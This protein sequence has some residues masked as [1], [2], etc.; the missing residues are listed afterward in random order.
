MALEVLFKSSF[1]FTFCAKVV[2]CQQL[3]KTHKHLFDHVPTD[4]LGIPPILDEA[5]GPALAQQIR[6]SK[7]VP[8]LLSGS[9]QPAANQVNM[10][11]KKAIAVAPLY[12][13]DIFKHMIA[14][15]SGM[16]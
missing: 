12:V 9:P 16:H 3:D 1:E 2:F 4:I 6:H 7:T 5:Q 13:L 11:H 15:P 10:T 8:C 14:G